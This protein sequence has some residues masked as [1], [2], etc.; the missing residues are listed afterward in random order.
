MQREFHDTR[1]RSIIRRLGWLD[2]RRTETAT[3]VLMDGGCLYVPEAE[4]EQMLA[5]YADSLNDQESVYLVERPS[6]YIR[7][8]ADLDIHV[9]DGADRESF[10]SAAAACFARSSSAH[11]ESEAAVCII[12]RASDKAVEGGWKIGIHII[13]PTTRVSIGEAERLRAR[14]LSDLERNA[15]TPKNSWEDAFDASVYRQGGLRMVGSRKMV[16]CSCTQGECSHRNRKVD[17]GRPYLLHSVL[18]AHGCASSEWEAQLRKNTHLLVKMCSIRTP[19]KP[20][21]PTPAPAEGE[22]PTRRFRPLRRASPNMG[23]CLA[24]DAFQNMSP[25]HASLSIESLVQSTRGT[26]LRLGGAGAQYCPNV[27]RE[28]RQSSVYIVVDARGASMRCY[29]KK[30]TCPTFSTG[31]QITQLGREL[32][33][34][35]AQKRGLPHG[36]V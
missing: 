4:F 20:T 17:A 25:Q 19:N 27:G 32:L 7:F 24:R 18:D 15:P 36:F 2:R 28:H 35:T 26:T 21:D 33:G 14:V 31:L 1:F 16:P 23:T 9:D 12:L 13:L 29:C 11:V 30:G 5:A 10:V 22:R 3:A 34:T 6:P 8:Y